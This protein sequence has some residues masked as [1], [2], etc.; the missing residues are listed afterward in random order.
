MIVVVLDGDLDAA[1]PGLV[2]WFHRTVDVPVEDA[3]AAVDLQP[4]VA[5]VVVFQVEEQIPEDFVYQGGFGGPLPDT[6]EPLDDDE[7]V[8]G[9]MLTWNLTN[10][11]PGLPFQVVISYGVLTPFDPDQIAQAFRSRIVSETRARTTAM[12]LEDVVIGG[13]LHDCNGNFVEDILDIYTGFSLDLDNDGVP[14]ECDV[15]CPWDCD[16]NNDG[17][18]SVTDLLGLLGQY[19]AQAPLS[20]TGGL[21]D[22]NSDGCVDIV[23]LLKLLAH[24]DPVGVGCP[25]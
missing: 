3:Q 22:F 4:V 23:D 1:V 17:I 19:D 7:G 9:T 14:D 6:V 13:L 18:V 15:L 8:L 5:V 21:C 25:Q 24:Y 12:P 11:T 2:G 16:G 20:C 10:P